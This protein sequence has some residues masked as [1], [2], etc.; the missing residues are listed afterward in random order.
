MVLSVHSAFIVEC[1]YFSNTNT[2]VKNNV[3]NNYVATVLLKY[4]GNFVA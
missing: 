3:K 4:V 2:N 1:Y